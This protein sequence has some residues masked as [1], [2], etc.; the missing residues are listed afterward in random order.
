MTRGKSP[1]EA[2]PIVLSEEGGVRY[3]HF[4]SPWIQGAMLVRAPTVIVIDYVARMMGWLMFLEP[5]RQILQLGLGAGALTRFSLANLHGSAVTTVECSAEVIDTARQWFALPRE[6]PRLRVVHADA[7]EFLTRIAGSGS[8][9]GVIQ[10]DLYDMHARGPVLDSVSFYRDCRAA[11]AP[12]GVCVVNL[13]GRHA[14]YARNLARIGRA[15]DGRVLALPPTAAGNVVAFAF[16][17]PPLAVGWRELRARASTL[18][19]RYGLDA[20]SWVRALRAGCSGE[21]LTV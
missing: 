3:L 2:V 14:S 21:F 5:P 7:G 20:P 4:G 12:A 1:N 13:F 15:F 8:E 9:Y 19:N 17:G 11:L 18:R 10:V 6:G 16:S